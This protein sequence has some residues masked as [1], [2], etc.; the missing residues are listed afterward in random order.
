MIPM[1]RTPLPFAV[2]SLVSAV[3][4]GAPVPRAAAAEGGDAFFE[5]KIRPLLTEHCYKCHSADAKKL[6]GNLLLDTRDGVL[7]GGDTGPAIVAGDVEKS[8]LIKAVRYKDHELQ[9]PPDKKLSD[10]QIADLEAWVKMGAPDT[11][12]AAAPGAKPA[13]GGGSPKPGPVDLVEGRK[14]WA[15]QPVRNPAIPQVKRTDWA[16]KPLDNFILAKLEEKHLAPAKPA[17]K[18][19]LIRRAYYD[20]IGLPPKPAEVDAFVN[21]NSPDAFAKVVDDLLSRP[22]YGERWARHWLDVVRY[23]D[24]FDS[25]IVGNELDCAF[26]YRYRDWVVNAFNKD[27]PYDQFVKMQIAGDLVPPAVPGGVNKDGLVATTVYLIGE[28]GGGDSDKDKLITDIVDDQVDLTGRAFLGVTLA[29]ARCHDHKFDPIPT[30]DYYGLAGIFFSSHILPDPGPKTNGPNTLRVPLMDQAEIEKRKEDEA[31]VAEIQQDTDKVIDEQLTELADEMLP[32]V[33]EYLAAAWDYKH[34]PEQAGGPKPTVSQ[35]AQQRNLHKYA[36]AQFLNYV[37]SPTFKVLPKAE[38]GVAGNPGVDGWRTADGADTPVVLAN[39]TD[40]PITITSLTLPPYSVNVHP[41]PNAGIAAAWRSPIAGKVKITGRAS[42]G[43][44]A[45]GDGVTWSLSRLGGAAAVE[46][47]SGTIANGGKQALAEG[48]G[49]K[50]L[51]TVEVAAGD[52]IQLA[53]LPKAEYSCDTTTVE[54]EIAELGGGKRTWNLS[55]DVVPDLLKSNPHPDHFGNAAVWHFYDMT[56][57]VPASFAAGSSMSRFVQ[58][59]AA[60][61]ADGNSVRQ[62]AEDV[63]KALMNISAEI[64]KLKSQGKD[65]SALATPDAAFYQTLTNPRGTFWVGARADESVLPAEARQDLA[66]LRTESATIKQALAQPIPYAN[67]M[68]EGGT[69]KS[70]FAGIQDVPVHVRGQYSKLGDVVPR[71]FPQV[72][73]GEHQPRITNGS[74]RKELSEWIANKDNPLTARVIVNRIWQGHFGEGIVRTTNNFGKLGTP[75]T[76]PEM[77]DYLATR[78]V[79]MGWSIKQLHREIMLSSTYQQQSEA[80]PAAE[81]ADPDNLLFGR[82]NRQRLDAEAIRDSMLAVTDR[83]DQTLGGPAVR[84]IDTPRRTLYMITIRSEKASYRNLFDAADAGAIVEKRVDSTVAPQALFMLNNKFTVAQARFLGRRALLENGDDAKKID[85]MYQTL[86]A[87]HAT[88]K[89]IEIAKTVMNEVK[90]AK[91]GEQVTE[92]LP[93][94]AYAQVLLCTNEFMY[95]D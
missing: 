15:F 51:E 4:A 11:R 5:T 49:G 55:K 61:G 83:L 89:E 53:I 33:D 10:R 67:A 85:W 2:V 87:R 91:T 3:L 52:M 6:K 31:R 80:E 20:L 35:F 71:H 32:K 48:T 17:D 36:L 34:L 8:L 68:Q 40:K 37:G 76:H 38:A 30:K 74:G 64:A 1:R 14:W 43:D 16:R 45:C 65:A 29:C 28:W 77:L 72:I 47:A 73:A 56:G 21:D 59:I 82:M 93:W 81:K 92:E 46:L 18:R 94:E 50:S 26:A 63:G 58:A 95:V 75:P 25:R 66:A 69:P 44:G 54:L 9:M 23:T 22:Q 78:F 62:A 88:D 39:K 7:K 24:S 70:M 27:L 57:Q 41:S 79:E 60:A 13:S 90:V 42:D 12:V 19:T 84:E 86:F